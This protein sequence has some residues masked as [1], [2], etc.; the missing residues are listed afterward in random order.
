VIALS[1]ELS[2]GNR[3]RFKSFSTNVEVKDP[4]L[5]FLFSSCP[6]DEPL[7]VI[8]KDRTLLTE[9]LSLRSLYETESK[10]S[11]EIGKLFLRFMS[12]ASIKLLCLV[13]SLKEH[14]RELGSERDS[15]SRSDIKSSGYNVNFG[16]TYS[17]TFIAVFGTRLMLLSP[18][19]CLVIACVV[20]L[21]L[22]AHNCFYLYA[23]IMNFKAVLMISNNTVVYIATNF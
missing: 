10:L 12:S 3:F 4:F 16:F 23:S 6:F 1:S 8:R 5:K 11:V 9:R 13:L 15:F 18:S 20:N 2:L 19:V 17:G 21:N 22:D 7:D 14:V